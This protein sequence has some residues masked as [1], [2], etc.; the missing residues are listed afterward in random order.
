MSKNVLEIT[1]DNFNSEVL[2]SNMPV[3][4]DFWAPWCGPCRAI[5][6]L[7]EESAKE[8][9]GKVKFCKLDVDQNSKTSVQFDIRGIPAIKIFVEGK[10][11]ETHVGVITKPQLSELLD[12]HL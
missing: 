1:D 10:E 8:Y 3:L 12:K 5:A 7:I 11:V 6:P 2:Q 9:Q 4:V